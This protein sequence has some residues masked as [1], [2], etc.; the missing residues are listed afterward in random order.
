MVMSSKWGNAA[1]E[2]R[3]SV[4][5]VLAVSFW[6]TSIFLYMSAMLP[7]LSISEELTKGLATTSAVLIG[8]GIL[9][10]RTKLMLSTTKSASETIDFETGVV[11]RIVSWVL[12]VIMVLIFIVYFLTVKSNATNTISLNIFIAPFAFFFFYIGRWCFFKPGAHYRK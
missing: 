12:F 4:R 8:I 7:L 5:S 10:F 6:L 3:N 11:L 2:N 1:V 9:I